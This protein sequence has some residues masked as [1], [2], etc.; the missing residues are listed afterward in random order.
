MKIGISSKWAVVILI[1]LI[2]CAFTV[3]AESGGE[4]QVNTGQDFTNPVTRFDIRYQYQS[5]GGDVEQNHTIL[6]VDKPIP[7]NKGKSGLLYL[8]ADMP[9]DYGNAPGTDNPNGDYEFGSGDLFMQAVY[10]PPPSGDLSWDA[11]G[12]GVGFLWPTA[13]QSQF[14]AEKYQIFPLLGLK[15]NQEQ[16]SKGSFFILL[17]KY[18]MDYADYSGGDSRDDIQTLEISPVIHYMIPEKSVIPY[19]DFIDLWSLEGLKFNFEDGST[20][21]SGDVFFPLDIMLGKMLNKS[22]VFSLEFQTP[23]YKDDTFDAYDWK[24]G[25]RI[26]FFF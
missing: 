11:W 8:R 19:F 18:F 1:L 23:L 2:V 21:N 7:L 22:T 25:F 10:I 6:R 12:Y 5:L 4:E 3:A 26:G 14:G 15:W 24:L 16:W 9:F 13:S 17:G 20:K